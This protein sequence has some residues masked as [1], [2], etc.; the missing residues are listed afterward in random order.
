MKGKYRI[1]IAALCAVVVLILMFMWLTGNLSREGKIK[2]GTVSVK[3]N[4]SGDLN[5][6]EV[7]ARTVPVETEVVGTVTA[8]EK[9]DISSRIM[10]EITEVK[11][12]AGDALNK[13][14]LLFVLDS[15]DAEARLAQ[16]REGLAAAEANLE[17]A[18]LDAGRIERLLEKEAATRQEHDQAQAMLK[19]AQA[20]VEAAKAA[21]REA[22]VHR[23]HARI[24]S[25]IGGIVIDRHADPGDIAAPGRPLMSI[26][27]PSGL[28]L[29]VAVTEHLR[30]KVNL[31]K[32][33]TASIDSIGKIFEGSIE[34][35]VPASDAAS[36]TFLARVSIPER[37]G[38]YPG[39]YG[40][41]WLPVGEKEAVCVPPDA[42]QRIGQLEMVTVVEN[43]IARMRAVRT[44]KTRSEGIEILSGLTPGEI[45]AVP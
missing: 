9:V 38:V 19:A 30:P 26:Y 24:V 37:E 29:D 25:P 8:R 44:G 5:T 4:A 27:D 39:M 31:D 28:R 13:G 23:S 16:A 12:D 36:R 2:P 21:V 22:E 18:S 35:I 45:I 20:S 14:Q 42:I 17:R 3:E 10:A 11:A 43:G 7:Q 1:I 40:R 6:I 41:I 15:R 34:E 33:V 32:T